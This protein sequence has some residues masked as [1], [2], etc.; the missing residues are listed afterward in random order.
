MTAWNEAIAQA[1]PEDAKEW[2]R[3]TVEVDNLA[4]VA[5][6]TAHTDAVQITAYGNFDSEL[7]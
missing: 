3:A 2:I 6:I 5:H 4:L 1:I 7:V